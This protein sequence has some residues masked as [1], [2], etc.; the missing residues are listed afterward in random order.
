MK[1]QILLVT[2]AL[3]FAIF[4]YT[5]KAQGE[6]VN[7]QET[8]ISC[9][10]TARRIKDSSCK[11]KLLPDKIIFNIKG[12]EFIVPNNQIFSTNL[13]TV[14]NFIPVHKY[15]E[16]LLIIEPKSTNQNRTDVLSISTN[17]LFG[18]IT[19]NK[20]YSNLVNQIS[21]RINISA[22]TLFNETVPLRLESSVKDNKFSK[23][24]QQLL[25]TKSCIRCDLRN[26]NLEG[27]NLQKSNLE[28]SNLEGANLS[29]ANLDEAYLVGTNL[30]NTKMSSVKLGKA[31]LYRA[32]MEKANLENANLERANF[33]N[34]N[35]SSAILRKS[36]TR[37]RYVMFAMA[38]LSNADLSDTR[39]SGAYFWSANMQ[40]I[41]L[42]NADFS[43]DSLYE[44]LPSIFSEADLSNANLTSTNIRNSEL[45]GTNLYRANL[46]KAKLS[47]SSFKSAKHCQTT[48]PDGKISNKDCN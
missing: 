28:G 39:L 35:L 8:N 9:K 1:T 46:H 7:S 36:S 32:S 11:I 45:V 3:P 40:N 24:L 25:T 22:E 10:L 15:A 14:E 2:L 37:G 21:E 26:V 5:D 16:F 42:S 43:V 31:I 41:N 27:A 4:I 12:Q 13:Y 18:I 44:R 23:N 20:K 6:N 17:N 29:K 33:Q 34:A 19:N 30:N 48:L 38:N 47:G